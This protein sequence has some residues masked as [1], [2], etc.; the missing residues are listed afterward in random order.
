[1]DEDDGLFGKPGGLFS[2]SKGLFDDDDDDDVRA[3]YLVFSICV[4][5]CP[6]TMS[7]AKKQK[8]NPNWI[9][10]KSHTALSV[11]WMT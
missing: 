3:F 1:M 5:K 8:Q 11:N 2:S 4:N 10:L 7:W 6:T 9:M